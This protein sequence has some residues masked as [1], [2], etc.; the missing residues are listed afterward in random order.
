MAILSAI[1]GLAD[2][3]CAF[4]RRIGRATRA[5]DDHWIGDAIG[6]VCLFAGLWLA[7]LIGWAAQ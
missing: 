5:L 3:W 6:V 4:M 2:G 1:I 7:L